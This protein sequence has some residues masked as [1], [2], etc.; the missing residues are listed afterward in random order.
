MNVRGVAVLFVIVLAIGAVLQA[1]AHDIYGGW[2]QP[3]T[4]RSCCSD[5]DCQPARSYRGDDGLAY[6]WLNGRWRPVPPRRV[7]AIP[8]PDGASHVCADP[9]TDEIFC[10]VEGQPKS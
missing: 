7:L 9:M 10:F 3:D 2:T 6:V 1:F 4:G 8:S 5:R